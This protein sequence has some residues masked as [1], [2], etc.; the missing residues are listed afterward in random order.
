MSIAPFVSLNTLANFVADFGAHQTIIAEGEPGIGK[1]SVLHTLKAKFPDHQVVYFDV[2]AMDV[3]DFG[4]FMPDREDG[5][6]KFYP[7]ELFGL[8]GKDKGKPKVYMFD[9]IGKVAGPMH[10]MLNRVMLERMLGPYKLHPDSRIFCTTNLST[11]GVG[12]KLQSH[13]V[14]RVTRVKIRKPSYTEW[15]DW[16]IASGKVHAAVIAWAKE[17]S[18]VFSSYTDGMNDKDMSTKEREARAFIF[19]PSTPGVP[20]VSPRSLAACSV[21]VE[22]RG[23][24]TED[25]FIA[26]LAGTVGMGA[27]V[28]MNAF[29]KVMDKMVSFDRII[30][31]P[32]GVPVVD[33]GAIPLMQVLNAVNRMK[34]DHEMSQFLIFME[35][36]DRKE[37]TMVFFDKIMQ[38][39]P[40][41]AGRNRQVIEWMAAR[42]NAA[43]I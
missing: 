6:L 1:S 9:E 37:L 38:A 20:F 16:A 36:M 27:A 12:D 15:F 23:D 7:N 39:K 34:T 13:T 11:D 8:T 21:F 26:L 22:K 19:N 31:D 28:N 2:P 41:I 42:D 35:R 18:I 33:T 17:N 29:F 25:E 14:N 4:M 3:P 40:E 43:L 24:Y 5:A 10:T 30:A 32:T